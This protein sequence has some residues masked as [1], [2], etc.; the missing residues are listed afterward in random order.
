MA[1]KYLQIWILYKG[2]RS[3]ID[4]KF[5]LQKKVTGTDGNWLHTVKLNVNK[6]FSGRKG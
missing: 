6:F 5:A 4:Y 2:Y 3:F 1:A